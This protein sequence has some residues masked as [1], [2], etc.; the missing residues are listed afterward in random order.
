MLPF[1][2][3]FE[4]LTG[5]SIAPPEGE[6]S[7]ESGP[8]SSAI[9]PALGLDALERD[10]FGFHVV[11]GDNVGENLV[12]LFG[13]EQTLLIDADR[14]NPDHFTHQ[15]DV[16]SRGGQ[17]PIRVI[18]QNL[19]EVRPEAVYELEKLF[20]R[21]NGYPIKSLWFI[22]DGKDVDRGL[23]HK[24]LM[25]CDR[26]VDADTLLDAVAF[27]W[28]AKNPYDGKAVGGEDFDY[29]DKTDFS[30]PYSS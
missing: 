8:L 27:G 1:D 23:Q 24:V 12:D 7:N 11:G 15:I 4:D 18:L 19:S 5:L 6:D 25:R 9:L 14:F 10:R 30:L 26:I 13:E 21:E 17:S 29:T 2:K 3:D 16:L 20:N 22:D 28:G